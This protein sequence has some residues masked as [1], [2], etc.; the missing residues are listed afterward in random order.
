T[1]YIIKPLIQ[2]KWVIVS[3]MAKGIDSYAHD[4][5]LTYNGATIAVLGGGFHHIY[6]RQNIPLFKQIA[7]KGLVLSE[8]APDTPPRK[9]HFPERNRI[10]SGLS[11]GTVVIEAT[12][13]SG[14]L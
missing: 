14:T 11:F 5:A 10:I 4:L 3:G 12:E 1:A 8:Y 2:Q 13:K 9:H 6:L 7:K